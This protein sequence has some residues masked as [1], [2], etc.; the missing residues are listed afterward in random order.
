MATSKYRKK[1][2]VSLGCSHILAFVLQSD[3]EKAMNLGDCMCCGLALTLS[4]YKESQWWRFKNH[5]LLKSAGV[6]P[7]ISVELKIFYTNTEQFQNPP[8]VVYVLNKMNNFSDVFVVSFSPY[9]D[10]QLRAGR[11]KTETLLM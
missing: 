6:L 11:I 1:N 3:F 5:V 4:Y 10:P 8:L 9:T 2:S 7:L